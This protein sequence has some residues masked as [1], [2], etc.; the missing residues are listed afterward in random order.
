MFIICP[1]PYCVQTMS[2]AHTVHGDS[3]SKLQS[4]TSTSA[5]NSLSESTV[6]HLPMPQL[7]PSKPLAY[8]YFSPHSLAKPPAISH[9]L[10][11]PPAIS[12]SLAKPPAISHSLAKPPAISH[13]LARLP[14]IP[15]SFTKPPAIPH[16]LTKPHATPH[17]LTKPHAVPHS[18]TH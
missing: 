4:V 1:C 8:R 7:R 10:A 17:S 18:F 5:K 9:S 6:A 12:H 11:K 14:A 2:S 15:P 16:S 13:S 3:T